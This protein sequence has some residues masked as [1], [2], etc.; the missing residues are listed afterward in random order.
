MRGERIRMDR[1]WPKP[2][3]SANRMSTGVLA[4]MLWR[5]PVGMRTKCEPSSVFGKSLA[6]A[7]TE[8]YRL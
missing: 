8:D 4:W 2:T 5:W 7:E 6:L 1:R 3:N